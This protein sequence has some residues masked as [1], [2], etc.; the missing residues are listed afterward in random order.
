MV[1][2]EP[3][4]THHGNSTTIYHVWLKMVHSAKPAILNVQMRNRFPVDV[5]CGHD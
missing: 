2:L 3:S 5:N 1:T 4:I